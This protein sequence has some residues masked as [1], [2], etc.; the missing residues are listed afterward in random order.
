MKLQETLTPAFQEEMFFSIK[1][2]N[3]TSRSATRIKFC[4]YIT[5]GHIIT[6][7]SHITFLC[8]HPVKAFVRVRSDN[9]I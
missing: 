8:R 9:I 5:I 4:Q 6:H 1:T 2:H 7:K 3:R